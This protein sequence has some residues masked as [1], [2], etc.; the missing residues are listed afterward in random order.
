MEPTDAVPSTVDNRDVLARQGKAPAARIRNKGLRSKNPTYQG[1]KL[2]STTV[3]VSL[4]FANLL[5]KEARKRKKNLTL[6]TRGL[7]VNFNRI[8]EALDIY[9][10]EAPDNA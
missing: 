3:R 9:F 5:R 6:L 8:E 4:G 7:E 2:K 10:S 1:A